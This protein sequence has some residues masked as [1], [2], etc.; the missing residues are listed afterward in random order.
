MH[1]YG[2][3]NIIYYILFSRQLYIWRYTNKATLMYWVVGCTTQNLKKKK[4][5]ENKKRPK[6]QKIKLTTVSTMVNIKIRIMTRIQ[7]CRQRA[8]MVV[9]ESLPISVC[10]TIYSEV[11]S[12]SFAGSRHLCIDGVRSTFCFNRFIR[13]SAV[14]RKCKAVDLS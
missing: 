11:R 12:I 2:Y 8:A 1:V 4:I 3:Y 9:D 5:T 7:Q 10:L 14:G 6:E 13:V